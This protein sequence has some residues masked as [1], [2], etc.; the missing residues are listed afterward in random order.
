MK[1]FSGDVLLASFNIYIYTDKGAPEGYEREYLLFVLYIQ[2]K[3]SPLRSISS[4]LGT[5]SCD[6]VPD[7]SVSLHLWKT[8]VIINISNG[9]VFDSHHGYF[10]C[11]LSKYSIYFSEIFNM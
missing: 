9:L 6:V 2:S 1:N 10:M 4:D 11:A 5:Y 7:Y 3:I 8:C